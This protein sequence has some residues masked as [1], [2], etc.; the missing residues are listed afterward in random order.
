MRYLNRREQVAYC[1]DRGLK[2]S[3]PQLDKLACKGGGPDYQIWG[4]QA[5]STPEQ[6]DAWIASKLSPPRKSTSAVRASKME[7][8]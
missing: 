1:N 8:A 2:I 6:L 3:K 5:V 7:V 4:N